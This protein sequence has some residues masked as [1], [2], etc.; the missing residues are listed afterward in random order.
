MSIL[1]STTLSDAAFFA[2]ETFSCSITFTNTSTP[3]GIGTRSPGL[4]RSV[5]IDHTRRAPRQSTPRRQF[6]VGPNSI[7][8]KDTNGN[9][10]LN[11]HGPA[12]DIDDPEGLGNLPSKFGQLGRRK[13]PNSRSLS[14]VTGGKV[15]LNGIDEED[16]TPPIQ[17]GSS[18]GSPYSHARR[19]ISLSAAGTPRGGILQDRLTTPMTGTFPGGPSSAS[20]K[21]Y[22][23]WTPFGRRS[24]SAGQMSTSQ[25]GFRSPPLSAPSSSI[26][27]GM[28]KLSAKQNEDMNNAF[29]VDLDTVEGTPRSSVDFYMGRNDSMESVV[30][31]IGGSDLRFGHTRRL[32]SI[33]RN[34]STVHLAQQRHETLLWSF[35]QVVG[36]FTVDESLVKRREFDSLK[37]KVMYGSAGAG[38]PGGAVGGG[39][40]GFIGVG[41]GLFNSGFFGT[42]NSQSSLADMQHRSDAKSVPVYS[43]PPSILFVDL[44]LGPGESK[45]YIYQLKLPNDIPPSH[46]GKAIKFTYNLIIGTHRAGSSQQSRIIQL[47]FRVFNHVAEN[48]LRPMY[49]LMNPVILYK[50]EAMTETIADAKKTPN[51]LHPGATKNSFESYIK[52][53]L[54]RDGAEPISPTATKFPI[55]NTPR[56]NSLLSPE[57]RDHSCK[58]AIEEVSRRSQKSEFENCG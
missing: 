32:S 58:H 29:S 39:S 55:V 13:K 7:S 44:H 21:Q 5:S 19:T 43:T 30:S 14:I 48:G 54:K 31:N 41:G 51:L 15:V 3:S 16:A 47:P 57:E 28:E 12:H 17:S 4:R 6:V 34:A 26:S 49:D 52:D 38:G 2:G 45:T 24:S 22:N 8:H 10:T 53:L 18:A 1:I 11:G 33:A 56:K 50:D 9:G 37:S 20:P 36:N 27:D 42:S 46:R 23:F 35:A 40:L 25:E